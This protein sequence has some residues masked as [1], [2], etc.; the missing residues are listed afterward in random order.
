MLDRY[1]L[2]LHGSLLWTKA[3]FYS[4]DRDLVITA[5]MLID[6]GASYSALSDHFIRAILDNPVPLSHR[7]IA[8]A[9]QSIMA[10]VIEVARFNCLG[11]QIDNFAIVT[12]PIPRNA[13]IDGLIGIDFLRSCGALIDVE[14]SEIVITK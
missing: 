9:S 14:R 4:P 2:N 8:T 7:S 3:A 5:R 13:F 11:K 12:L 1:R 10:P 6:T